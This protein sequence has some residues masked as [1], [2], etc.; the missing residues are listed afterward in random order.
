MGNVGKGLL[1]SW[2]T[3]S[4]VVPNLLAWPLQSLVGSGGSGWGKTA[5]KVVLVHDT[6][7]L[8]RWIR[9]K[10]SITQHLLLAKLRLTKNLITSTIPGTIRLKLNLINTLLHYISQTDPSKFFKTY[11][12]IRKT[13]WNGK[14]NLWWKLINV[15]TI[16][17]VTGYGYEVEVETP[18]PIIHYGS[19]SAPSQP[20]VGKLPEVHYS[21]PI[22]HYGDVS[23][24][25]YGTNGQQE[26]IVSYHPSK[27]NYGVQQ[28]SPQPWTS[29]LKNPLY[30]FPSSYE[31]A[32]HESQYADYAGHIVKSEDYATLPPVVVPQPAYSFGS[33]ENV[34][35]SSKFLRDLMR[36]SRL[37][38]KGDE[39]KMTQPETGSSSVEEAEGT[40]R[41]K[42]SDQL[43]TLSG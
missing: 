17:P 39:D 35:V 7:L 31:D 13:I 25:N 38:G 43:K 19:P 10:F 30:A 4:I 32:K 27:P 9:A 3:K 21:K 24:P 1:S 5:S 42:F 23:A 34:V 8:E 28:P 15:K 33:P 2:W 40:K 36:Q 11:N 29:S 41:N 6:S 20:W 16:A 22:V 12:L 18:K 26:T 14:R 37:S